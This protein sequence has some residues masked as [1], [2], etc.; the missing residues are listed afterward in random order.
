MDWEAKCGEL[1]KRVAELE[2]ENRELRRRL[3]ISEMDQPMLIESPRTEAQ[4]CPSPPMPSVHM[5]LIFNKKL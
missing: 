3:G 2:E 5:I 1:Q 4:K